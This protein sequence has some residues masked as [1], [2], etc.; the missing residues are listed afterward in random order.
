MS[1]DT[2]VSSAVQEELVKIQR[3]RSVFRAHENATPELGVEVFR[4]QVG[5]LLDDFKALS[6]F[7][8]PEDYRTALLNGDD[9]EYYLELLDRTWQRAAGIGRPIADEY[10][11][12]WQNTVV[13]E[14]VLSGL[15]ASHLVARA[16]GI[17]V[18][19]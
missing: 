7:A 2:L 16:C 17:E 1:T 11:I 4:D 5:P 18:E 3:I 19:L 12:A 14:A 13:E 9:A 8:L 10:D 6:L 15:R